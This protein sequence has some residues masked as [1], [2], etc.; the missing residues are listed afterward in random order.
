MRRRESR[1]AAVSC[2]ARARVL[3]RRPARS[4][5]AAANT[6]LELIADLCVESTRTVRPAL[7]ALAPRGWASPSE[8]RRAARR[9]RI[10]RQSESRRASTRWIESRASRASRAVRA[11]ALSGGAASAES[12]GDGARAGLA[13]ARAE[14]GAASARG[15][16]GTARWVESVRAA[17]ARLSAGARPAGVCG[18]STRGAAG[19]GARTAGAGRALG[20]VP[21][22]SLAERSGARPWPGATTTLSALAVSCAILAMSAP[23][24][25]VSGRRMLRRSESSR[26]RPGAD[27]SAR[28]LR[29]SESRSAYARRSESCGEAPSHSGGAPGFVP[30]AGAPSLAPGRVVPGPYSI[31]PGSVMPGP[32]PSLGVVGGGCGSSSAGSSSG[33]A[34]SLGATMSLSGTTS[35]SAS[36]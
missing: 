35:P 8:S 18:T 34:I 36:R 26:A 21:S 4:E 16:R 6:R 23:R 30:G 33:F 20:A 15:R 5:S 2:G 28:A 12:A 24:P 32:V 25:S 11:R 10:S 1:A 3:S 13:S 29:S 27:V 7:S 31:A 14:S 22:E 17:L 9:L 19:N